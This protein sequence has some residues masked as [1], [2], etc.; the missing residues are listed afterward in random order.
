MALMKTVVIDDLLSKEDHDK[1]QR[2]IMAGK[3]NFIP[4]MSYATVPLMFPSMGFC[5]MMKHPDRGIESLLYEAVAVPV[6]NV[7]I[8]KLDLKITDCVH[9]RAFLQ[10]PMDYKFRRKNN[11]IH[12]DIPDKHYAC[13]YY[14]NDTDGD[15]IIYEQTLND[16]PFGETNI[17][18]VEHK[19]VTP[20]ANRIVIFDGSRYHCSSQPTMN[21]RAIINYNL[22]P[23]E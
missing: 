10:I 3:W 1:Y 17:E 15:T 8:K 16:V 6:I 13:V 19:R 18:L 2:T 7:A 23:T 5:Q 12:I 9:C 22:I 21:Y 14:L 4:D 11:G 20:K